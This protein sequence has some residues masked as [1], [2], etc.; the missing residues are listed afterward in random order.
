[1]GWSGFQSKR[2]LA[3]IVSRDG[4]S[5]TGRGPS[6]RDQ[7]IAL[8]EID[9]T[10]ARTLGLSDGQKMTATVHLDPPVAHTIN[11]EPVTSADWEAIELNAQYLE[12]NLMNQIRALPNPNYAKPD[13]PPVKA[14]PLT[15]HMSPTSSANVIVTSLDPAPPSTSPFA[16]IAPAAEVIVAPKTRKASRTNT[17]DNRSASGTSRKS[18]RGGSERT[19]EQKEAE[20][21]PVHL[22]R[23]LDR[24]KCDEYFEEEEKQSSQTL[25]VWIDRD[26]IQS[27]G[28]RGVSYVCVTAIKPAGLEAPVED[29]K[30]V[31]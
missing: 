21:R 24:S 28:L 23:G 15:I 4:I 19:K 7:E 27:K 25:A 26:V 20:S 31:V 1:M 14:H 18:G 2:K 30:S 6:G 12:T 29:R 13:G 8:V 9:S 11:I 17:R 5:G 3:P 16:K 10:F 22:F